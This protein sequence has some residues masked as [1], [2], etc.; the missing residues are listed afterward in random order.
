MKLIFICLYCSTL[1]KFLSSQDKPLEEKEIVS[2]FLQIVA[3]IT[4]IHKHNILHR[5]F[6]FINP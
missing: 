1:A 5:Y 2:L 4:H 6:F 3:A